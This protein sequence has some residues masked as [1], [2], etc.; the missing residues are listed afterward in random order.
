[1]KQV[2]KNKEIGKVIFELFEFYD[3]KCFVRGKFINETKD[4]AR[5]YTN[6][7]D[8]WDYSLDSIFDAIRLSRDESPRGIPALS[9]ILIKCKNPNKKNKYRS[10]E[11]MLEEWKVAAE[12]G[13]QRAI[14][15]LREHHGIEIDEP[16]VT[17]EETEQQAAAGSPYAKIVLGLKPEKGE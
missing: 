7:L 9:E 5:K 2:N 6:E 4:R 8:S 17:I 11:E 14:D 15:Y 1:M 3:P 13:D 10:N 16:E 12:G